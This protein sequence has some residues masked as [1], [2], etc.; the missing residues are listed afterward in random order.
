[1]IMYWREMLENLMDVV[2]YAMAYAPDGFPTRN[3][4]PANEQ[5]NLDRAFEEIREELESFAK[6]R[7][8]SEAIA[9]CRLGIEESY[10]RYC[11]GKKNEG[12]L[13]LQ[14]VYHKLEDF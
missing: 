9:E 1:M 11:Q 12:F 3:L 7:G 14:D 2:A 4:L 13:K 6:A 8:E 10:L 5:M